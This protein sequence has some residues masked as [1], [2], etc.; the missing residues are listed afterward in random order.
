M[1]EEIAE[2]GNIIREMFF[3]A[4]KPSPSASTIRFFHMLIVENLEVF[5]KCKAHSS[6]SPWLKVHMDLGSDSRFAT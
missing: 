6:P 1:S 4:T 5:K 2:S 3:A